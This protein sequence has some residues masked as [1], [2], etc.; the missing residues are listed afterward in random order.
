[1]TVTQGEWLPATPPAEQR[2]ER[3]PP[4]HR[5]LLPDARRAELARLQ[6]EIALVSA[7]PLVTAVLETSDAIL[8]VLNPERQI[9][10]FNGRVPEVA[11]AGDL[12]GLRPGEAFGCV[13]AA[14]PGGCGAA[15]ACETCG[16][17]A[18]VVGCRSQRRPVEAEC[19]LRSEGRGGRTLEF[20]ARAA[21][22]AVEDVEF[23]VLSLRDISAERRRQA[24]EQVF[25]HDVLNT[26]A[27]LRTWATLL[28]RPTTDPQRAAGR[29]EALSRQVER[30]IKHHRAL[31]ACESGAL[32]TERAPVAAGAL[33]ADLAAVVSEHPAAGGRR[34]ELPLS[35][36]HCAIETDAALCVRVLV[37]TVVNALEATPPG[38]VVRV[39]CDEDGG[40]LRF[41]VHNPGEMPDE[42][43]ARVFQRSFSTKGTPGRGL[44]TYG[45]KL[46]G[47]RYLGGSVTF[48][49]SPSDGTTFT[50]RLPRAAET[51][52]ALALQP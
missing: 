36:P 19:A 28:A 31:S 12:H 13:N 47:E 3:L 43:K 9:V 27:G 40:G 26:V 8:L 17:L 7:S 18:A 33:L 46:F 5:T 44:G 23:T 49:S 32:V 48:T 21:P 35:P 15:P 25:F 30:E 50:I 4:G 2:F 34:L 14:G 10:A 22:V 24:L 41:R 39:D 52:P 42:V 38:G 11:V 51:T 37:N 16:A 20:N 45:M 29:I 6:R 1:M